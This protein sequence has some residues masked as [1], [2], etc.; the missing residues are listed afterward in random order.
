MLPRLT[1]ATDSVTL[2]LLAIGESPVAGVGVQRQEQAITAQFAQALAERTHR[3]VAWR[4]FGQNGATI[5]ETLAILEA[6]PADRA[7]PPA[8]GPVQVL[9]L[10][11]G[12]ND[13]T[14]FRSVQRY[15]QDLEDLLALASKRWQP[16]LTI[17]AGVPPLQ[18][19]PALPQP[20]RV[21]LGLKAAALNQVTKDVAQGRP[22]TLYV[23]MVNALDTPEWMAADGYHPSAEGVCH[24]AMQLAE[25]VSVTAI[26][27]Q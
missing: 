19:F 26:V 3:P 20:L 15:R 7:E 13:S 16:T 23:P 14:A 25:A 1:P 5:R 2:Q 17:V 9:L 11:C 4:A 24:W 27:R 10:A 12:V 6:P 18:V 21:V 8:T 22:D